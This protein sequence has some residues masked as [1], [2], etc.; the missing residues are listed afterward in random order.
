M[1]AFLKNLPIKG[2][3]GR[4]LR[5]PHLLGYVGDVKQFCTFGIWSNTQCI[6]VTQCIECITL[7]LFTQGRAGGG[8]EVKWREGRE[9]LYKRGR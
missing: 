9:A 4:C 6:T 5:P 7:Y 2:L 1:S 8:E 3:G